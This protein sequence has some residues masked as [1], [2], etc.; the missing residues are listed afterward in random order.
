[1]YAS[2]LSGS[3][4]NLQSLQLLV[5]VQWEFYDLACLT[6]WYHAESFARR[7]PHGPAV[8]VYLQSS[9]MASQPLKSHRISFNLV[10]EYFSLS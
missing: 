7:R 4:K 1:M 9:R 8:L 6:V 5:A 10:V 2:N 3:T